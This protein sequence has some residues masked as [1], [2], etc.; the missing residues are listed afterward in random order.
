[1]RTLPL[2]ACLLLS[3]CAQ[4]V[5]KPA[6]VAGSTVPPIP[7]TPMVIHSPTETVT[8]KDANSIYDLGNMVYPADATNYLW[9]LQKSN[10]GVEWVALMTNC[11]YKGPTSQY[12]YTNTAHESPLLFRMVGHH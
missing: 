9:D 12:Y 1:M 6:P 2:I 10:N 4:P 5:L 8:P 11:V 7:P 3:G